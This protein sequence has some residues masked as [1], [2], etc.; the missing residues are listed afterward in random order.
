MIN[1]ELSI[2]EIPEIYRRFA[3]AIGDSHWRKRAHAIRQEI[4]GNPVLQSYLSAENHVALQLDELRVLSERYGRVPVESIADL[5]HYPALVLC[6]QVLSFMEAV[7]GAHA[8]RMR[9]RFHGGL[10][11][12]ADLRGLALEFTGASHFLRRGCHVTW[13]EMTGI[14]TYDLLVE[15]LGLAGLDVECKSISV[16]KGRKIHVRDGLVFFA[17]VLQRLKKYVQHLRSGVSL[18]VT[19]PDRLPQ[20]YAQRVVIANEVADALLVERSGGNLSAGATLRIEEFD[21]T[22]L[23]QLSSSPTV[24]EIRPLVD[25]VSGTS[26]R[27][28]MVVGTV[29]GGALSLVLQSAKDDAVFEEL[30]A[31][32]QASA[33]DQLSGKRAGLFLVGLDGTSPEGLL[34]TARM[35]FDSNEPVTAIRDAVSSYL[36]GT[37]R[38]HVVGVGFLSRDT[39]TGRADGNF[40]V[41]GSAYYFRRSKSAFWSD[42]YSG[43]FAW[44]D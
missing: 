39:L 36:H 35:E 37:S 43:L 4:K 18:V 7:P 28:A 20:Q 11:N 33:R 12:P 19:L 17:L 24:Q 42:A 41:A 15:D 16:D 22:L 14:G 13:P 26:N 30:F 10:R 3:Q 5:R 9:R 29:A 1:I 8:E 31:T 25:K 38:D 27:P 2:P 6:A 21:T 23:G 44:Q 40:S 32:L 34:A